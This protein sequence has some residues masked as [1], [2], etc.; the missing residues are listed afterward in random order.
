M[1]NL[2]RAILQSKEKKDLIAKLMGNTE[3][4]FNELH[5][6]YKEKYNAKKML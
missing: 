2:L 5:Y 1:K 6:V 3:D 4:L